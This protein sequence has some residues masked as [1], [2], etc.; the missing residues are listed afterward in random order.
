MMKR[1]AVIVL[2]FI[3]TILKGQIST[4]TDLEI[5]PGVEYEIGGITVS[6][7]D[8][9]DKTVVILLSGLAVGDKITV[10]GDNLT[11]AVKALWKQRLFSDISIQVTEKQG[12]LIFLNI[13]LEELPKLSKFYFLGVKKSWKDDLREELKL[14]RGSIVTENLIITSGNKIKRYFKEKGYLDVDVKIAQELDTAM[15]NYV[16]LGFRIAT[17]AKIKIND[18]TFVGNKEVTE[19]TLQKAMK[20]TREKSFF[21]NIFKSSKLKQAEYEADKRAVIDKFNEL[22]YRDARIL[23]DSVYSAGPGLIN[24]EIHVEEG[25]KYYFRNITFVGNSKYST[26]IL[27]RILRIEKGD[28]YD[29]KLLNE[30][31]SLDMNGNDITTLY[32]DNGYLFSQ[33]LPVEIL[34]ENDSIDIEIRIREGSQAT[35]QKVTITGNDRTN[36]HVIYR[37]VRT[38]PGDLFSKSQIQRTI[39]EL[40][41]LGYFDQQ[42]LNVVPKPNPETGTVDLEYTVVE[43]STSQLELQ[44]GW[45]G[46]YIVGT[47]GLNFNNFSARNILNGKSWQPL[48]S[49]DGQTISLRAQSNGRQ[50]QSYSFSFTEPWLGGKKPQSF[51]VSLYHNIQTNGLNKN[52]PLRQS[53]YITGVNV[54]LGKRLKWPDD[55]FTIY[56]G[57]EYRR[58]NMNNYPTSF[59][60]FNNG[61][62]RNINYKLVISRNSTDVPIFPTKGSQISGTL[63]ITPPFSLLEDKDWANIPSEEKYAWI[64]YHKWKFNADWFTPLGV[65]NKLVL[66]AHAEFGFLGDFNNEIGL[67]PFERF[68]VGGDGLQNFVIDG[69]EVIGLRGYPNQTIT[70]PGGGALYN[71]FIIETR[72][73]ISPNP[74]AQIFALAFL[75]GGNNFN[76]FYRYR[77]FEL[78]RSAGVGLRIFMPMFG[79]LGVDIG[80][81]Y[82]PIPGTINASGWQTH[83]IIG[84]QF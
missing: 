41:Q 2:L 81:G 71:K 19:K 56:H 49:G 14:Q 3:S 39:R 10:P 37:E 7:S 58:F 31:V 83:F 74:S 28:I 80:Y 44:G 15:G 63:E 32:L 67:P 79:L 46:G 17:G 53:L 75:E 5:I 22:G 77:P 21:K 72:F 59:L 36:D 65:K 73:L 43:R 23:K 27:K 82:D 40:A 61:I 35:I 25:R 66:R 12:S 60:D 45:G 9:L 29:S 26:D 18:I 24:V 51:T 16:I 11:K 38:K 50:F 55:Y 1:I 68:Y 13:H 34:V 47:L 52:D 64:E 76:N 33:V 30:R 62:S 4:T 6:G 42:Q 48:P 84:Q 8:N 54:G 57:L 20:E 69:R 78:K 70:P